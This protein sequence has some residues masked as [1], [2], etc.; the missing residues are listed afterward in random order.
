ME[1]RRGADEAKAILQGSR[2]GRHLG[3][4]GQAVKDRE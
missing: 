3:P 4:V 1:E 2:I